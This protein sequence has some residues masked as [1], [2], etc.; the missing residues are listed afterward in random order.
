MG[1]RINAMRSFKGGSGSSFSTVMNAGGQAYYEVKQLKQ[2]LSGDS[3]PKETREPKDDANE[4]R[5]LLL[6]KQL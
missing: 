3:S 6:A 2:Q 5:A 1:P 4:K